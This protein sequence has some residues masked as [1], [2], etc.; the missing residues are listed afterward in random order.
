MILKDIFFAIAVVAAYL[1]MRHVAIHV[2]QARI[3]G[4]AVVGIAISVSTYVAWRK[5]RFAYLYILPGLTTL[6]IVISRV[7]EFYFSPDVIGAKRSESLYDPDADFDAVGVMRSTVMI[8]ILAGTIGLAFKRIFESRHG[9]QAVSSNNSTDLSVMS[10]DEN[11]Y[12]PPVEQ[13]D[14]HR[15]TTS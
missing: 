6:L 1:G 5:G 11:P 4:V 12:T 3:L 7:A 10:P 8:M 15:R 14:Q 13:A 9:N 2:G